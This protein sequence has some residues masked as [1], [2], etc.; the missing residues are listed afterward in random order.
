MKNTHRPKKTRPSSQAP[1]I[2]PGKINASNKSYKSKNNK[3]K[4]K[5]KK[6]QRAEEG[7]QGERESEAQQ[8]GEEKHEAAIA[9]VEEKGMDFIQRTL[10][11]RSG[12][13]SIQTSSL[14]CIKWMIMLGKHDA[15]IVAALESR[16]AGIKCG[17][18]KRLASK[19]CAAPGCIAYLC[20]RSAC[21]SAHAN[22]SDIHD[23]VVCG[24]N[25]C[26]ACVH[27]NSCDNCHDP[28]KVTPQICNTGC[29]MCLYDVFIH[30][31]L[32]VCDS[33]NS[34]HNGWKIKHCDSCGQKH[35]TLGGSDCTE[36][37]HNNSNYH[38]DKCVI[39]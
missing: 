8:P 7:L 34:A 19:A 37:D 24:T 38:A 1:C 33:C 16:V 35:C 30:S 31:T 14:D 39:C 17:E 5:K 25:F 20:E 18:C 9:Q 32:I 12:K 27:F 2:M 3:K 11:D 10:A 29:Y 23:C 26:R 22:P 6:K 4:K 28:G 21:R 36:C 15:K 13:P